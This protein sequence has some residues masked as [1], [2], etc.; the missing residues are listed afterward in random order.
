MGSES[1]PLGCAAGDQSGAAANPNLDRILFE[2]LATINEVDAQDAGLPDPARLKGT[3]V[4]AAAKAAM[5]AVAL[6]GGTVVPQVAQAPADPPA[7]VQDQDHGRRQGDLMDAILNHLDVSRGEMISHLRTGGTLAELAEESGSSG[8]EL[9]Q[10]LLAVADEQIEAALEDGRIDEDQ[11]GRLHQ[12]AEE[13]ITNLVFSTHDGPP[14]GPGLGNRPF[15]GLVLD[16][17]MEFLDLNKGQV[18]SHVR[19]GG[20]L[21]ELAAENGSSGPELE[22]ALTE[23]VAEVLE[24]LV[25]AG[26]ITQ[27]QADRLLERAAGRIGVIVYTVHTPGNGQ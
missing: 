19:T 8:E 22:A 27:E 6:V 3:A 25:E 13:R 21:A 9:V 20:T 7:A 26:R 1:D 11:A 4:F 15:R 5:A 24:G 23:A 17:T 10:V 12:R 18:V 2:Q 16:T 14:V